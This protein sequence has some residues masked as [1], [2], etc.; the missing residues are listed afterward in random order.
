MPRLL[1]RCAFGDGE[2]NFLIKRRDANVVVNNFTDGVA[3]FVTA[4]RR[5]VVKVLAV[6]RAAILRNITAFKNR[7]YKR[8][9][10]KKKWYISRNVEKKLHT[11]QKHR[12]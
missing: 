9:I 12:Y 4:M 6:A 1:Y 2:V 8:Q 5:T 10:A 11:R 3:N 7:R